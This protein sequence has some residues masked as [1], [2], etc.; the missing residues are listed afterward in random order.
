VGEI[1]STNDV[2]LQGGFKIENPVATSGGDTGE[3]VAEGEEKIPLFLRH[4]DRLVTALDFADITRRVPGVDVGRVEVL[5]LFDPND[6]EVPKPGVVTLLVIPKSD[7]VHPLWPEPDRL[8][9]RR[10]CDHL[11]PRRL[12]TTEIYVRG[13]SYEDVT[14]SVGIEVSEGYY[15]DEVVQT[16]RSRLETYLSALPPG[17]PD[18]E[19]WPLERKLQKKELEAVAA[20]VSGV[21]YVDSLHLAVGKVAEIQDAYDG[22]TGLRLPRVKTIAVRVGAAETLEELTGDEPETDTGEEIMPIAVVPGV[23]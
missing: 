16:V 15:R 21:A 6:R 22:L 8:F 20:R 10:V 7:A 19:G 2:R 9:L 4:R 14:L 17:G 13:P 23:C 3:T 5:P 18:E 12:V 11:A 1:K